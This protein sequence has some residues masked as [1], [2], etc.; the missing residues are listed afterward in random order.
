MYRANVD[1]Q[2]RTLGIWKGVIH[3]VSHCFIT[4]EK[5]TFA[6]QSLSRVWLF[7]TPW[8]AA[9]QAF[10]SFTISRSFLRLMSMESEMPPDH[11]ILCCPLSQHQ[12]LFQ[13]VGFFASG[14]QSIG[15]SVSAS[16]A[17]LPMN[18]QGWFPLGVTGLILAVQGPLKS[19]LQHHNSNFSYNTILAIAL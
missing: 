8:T 4:V 7:P 12:G 2:A 16:A 1:H 5:H 9:R 18:I 15:T 10:L 19:L 6:V 14:G 17:V 3:H 11:L 13:W